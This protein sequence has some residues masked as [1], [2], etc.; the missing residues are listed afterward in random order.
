[1]KLKNMCERVL[2]VWVCGEGG[3]RETRD[4]TARYELATAWHN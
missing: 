4:A 2:V 1:M 3:G